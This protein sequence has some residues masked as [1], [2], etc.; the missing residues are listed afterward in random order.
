M[1]S[2]RDHLLRT[3][4]LVVDGLE[5]IGIPA[6]KTVAYYQRVLSRDVRDLYNGEMEMGAFV[7][8]MLRLIEEQFR[9]AWNEGMRD[10]DLDPA[11]DMTDEWEAILQDAMSSELDFVEP[12][13]DAIREAA[14]AGNPIQP[15]LDRVTM[16]T[17]RYNEMVSLARIT[18]RPDDRYK[19]VY[20][21]TEHCTTCLT[22]NGI[23]ATGKEWAECPYQPQGENLE[24]RGFHCQCKLEYTEEPLTEGGIPSL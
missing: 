15:L 13:A 21:D 6:I 8:D 11:K 12:F 17:N 19:W 18:T 3:L 10:N 14:A 1:I 16:W 5:D 22:L 4:R 2:P 24:C 20:G 9:R 7:D 23:V